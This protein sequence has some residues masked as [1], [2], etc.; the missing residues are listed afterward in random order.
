MHLIELLNIIKGKG[1]VCT[2]HCIYVRLVWL[3]GGGAFHNY[4]D[5]LEKSRGG[6]YYIF[7]VRFAIEIMYTFVLTL[8]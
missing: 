3:R 8:R 5:T 1:L 6:F 4:I 7:V 2:I